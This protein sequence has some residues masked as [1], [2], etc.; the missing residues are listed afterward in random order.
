MTPG[1]SA[2]SSACRNTPDHEG[3]VDGETRTQAPAGRGEAS[4]EH[5]ARVV[6][7]V[8]RI[9]ALSAGHIRNVRLPITTS[10]TTRDRMSEGTA[11]EAAPA[12]S[13]RGNRSVAVDQSLTHTT[14]ADVRVDQ[15]VRG[16]F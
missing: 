5:V 7:L 2:G 12:E 11:S 14:C 9:T 6:D 16:S 13:A 8:H 1:G 3:R 10:E 15:K 4:S